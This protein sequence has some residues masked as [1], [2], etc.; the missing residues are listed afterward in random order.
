MQLVLDCSRCG[1]Q[2]SASS[3]T[4]AD[5]ILDRMFNEGTWFALA[6]AETFSEMVWTA[7]ASRHRIL[8]PECGHAV[9]VRERDLNQRTRILTPG[10]GTGRGVSRSSTGVLQCGV[11]E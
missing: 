10:G 11:N 1:C 4:P 5:V 9:A 3:D 6:Q 8:C 7:L 2:F